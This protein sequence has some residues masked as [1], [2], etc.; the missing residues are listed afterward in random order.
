MANGHGSNVRVSGSDERFA[1]LDER[2]TNLRTGVQHLERSTADGFARLDAKLGEMSASLTAGQKT[3]WS[4]IWTAVG[5]AFSVLL[6]IGYLVYTPI[7]LNQV[8]LEGGLTK[9]AD[10][11]TSAIASGP[12]LY[13][14]RRESDALRARA[15]E[16]RAN[17]EKDI[18][19]LRTEKLPRNEWLLRNAA[20]D[21]EFIDLRRTVEQ[22]RQDFGGTYSLRD[23]IADLKQRLERIEVLRER[24]LGAAK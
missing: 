12:D 20:V 16:D 14:P 11:V 24:E 18:D 5:V 19:G 9:L 7:Q 2:V 17:A 23:A 15:A 3:P 22:I 1:A 13:V 8:R 10:A 21:A 4:T 6:G